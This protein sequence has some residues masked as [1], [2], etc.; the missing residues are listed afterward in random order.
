MCAK[1]HQAFPVLTFD[2]LPPGGLDV[3][4]GGSSG[5]RV[6]GCLKTPE[7]KQGRGLRPYSTIRPQTLAT[8]LP[9]LGRQFTDLWGP[10]G[11]PPPWSCPA[12]LCL[13]PA[14]PP[15]PVPVA[16]RSLTPDP[17]PAFQL[18]SPSRPQTCSAGSGL[19][20]GLKARAPGA[21]QQCCLGCSQP[22]A[23]PRPQ[24]RPAVLLLPT[25]PP[26]LMARGSPGPVSVLEANQSWF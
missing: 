3:G 15:T 9:A 2:A 1:A 23:T 14:L 16:H 24:D 11:L 22:P 12:S 8:V 4:G 10:R 18:G 21:A 7:Q 19:F 13:P 17:R 6:P 26:R 25:A 20:S 5:N